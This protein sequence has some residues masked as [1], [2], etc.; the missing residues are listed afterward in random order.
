MLIMLLGTIWGV[1]NN[2]DFYDTETKFYVDFEQLL[3]TRK[4]LTA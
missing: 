2:R 1:E 4:C 3:I